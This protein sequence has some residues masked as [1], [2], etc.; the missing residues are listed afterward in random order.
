MGNPATFLGSGYDADDPDGEN[1]IVNYV[2]YSSQNGLLSNLQTFT[3][4]TLSAG[5]H[6]IT[7]TVVDDE[8]VSSAPARTLVYVAAEF[9]YTHMPMLRK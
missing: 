2:W 8:G 4:N 9:Y 6:I 5:Q 7:L 1:N 3:T